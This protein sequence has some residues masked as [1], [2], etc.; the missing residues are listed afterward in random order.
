MTT[1]DITLFGD[2][3]RKIEKALGII[4]EKDTTDINTKIFFTVMPTSRG[5]KIKISFDI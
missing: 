5:S 3:A 1:I 2:Q 4:Y